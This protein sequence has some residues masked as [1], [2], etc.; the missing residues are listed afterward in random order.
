MD[1]QMPVLDGYAAT[2]ALRKLP[3]LSNL[4]VIAMTANAMAGDREKV[5]DAGM[6]D[7]IAKPINF[8]QMFATLARWLRPVRSA[9]VGGEVAAPSLTDFPIDA[10]VGLKSVGGDEE[11]FRRVL[12]MFLKRESD[13]LGLKRLHRAT[14]TAMCRGMSNSEP[15]KPSSMSTTRTS[16]DTHSGRLGRSLRRTRARPSRPAQLCRRPTR[17]VES[18]TPGY[19][20]PKGPAISSALRPLCN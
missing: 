7:H 3:E 4:P 6:N 20:D 13:F 14:F 9:E 5:I 16:C 1:C 8:E 17:G 12:A 18:A 11:L 15:K 19:G 10:S 2:R